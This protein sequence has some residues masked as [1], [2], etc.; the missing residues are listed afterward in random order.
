VIPE[1]HHSVVIPVG[2]IT[3]AVLQAI[4][5]ARAMKP[6]HMV[7]IKVVSEEE[8]RRQAESEWAALA[9]GVPLE[10]IESPYRDLAGPIMEFIDRLDAGRDDDLITVLIPEFVIHRWWTQPLHNHS[11][12]ALKARLLFRPNTVVTSIPVHV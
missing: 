12:F 8:G 11:A 3:P 2:R 7:A 10:I 9:C 6:D 1:V 5:Y 4:G